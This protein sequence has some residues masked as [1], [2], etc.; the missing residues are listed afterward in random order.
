TFAMMVFQR[1][2]IKRSYK[3]LAVARNSYL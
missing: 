3:S 2:R 1:R